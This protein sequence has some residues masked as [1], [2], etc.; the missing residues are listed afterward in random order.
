MTD[1]T[2]GDSMRLSC[3]ALP[4]CVHFKHMSQHVHEP[5]ASTGCHTLCVCNLPG[6]GR[7]LYGSR[8]GILSNHAGMRVV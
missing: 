7:G 5:A 8:R 3:D 4:L 1:R 2:R 6:W